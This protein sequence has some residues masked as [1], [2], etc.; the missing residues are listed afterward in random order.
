MCYRLKCVLG[1]SFSSMYEGDKGMLK[2]F[3]T[4]SGPLG[5]SNNFMNVY[6]GVRFNISYKIL[7]VVSSNVIFSPADLNREIKI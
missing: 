3:E 5:P 2:I 4:S 6:G 7:L 1:P